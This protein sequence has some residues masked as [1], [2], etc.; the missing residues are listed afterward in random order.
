MNSIQQK[1]APAPEMQLQLPDRKSELAQSSN[2]VRELSPTELAYIG[3]GIAT[4]V[5]S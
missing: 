1:P 4:L 2:G 3:G 5:F